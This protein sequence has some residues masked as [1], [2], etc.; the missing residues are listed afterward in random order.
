MSDFTDFI[1]KLWR[2]RLFGFW[3]FQPR[4]VSHPDPGFFNQLVHNNNR[5]AF[6]LL[7]ASPA[8]VA[9]FRE[10]VASFCLFL[11]VCHL[12]LLNTFTTEQVV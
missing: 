4:I 8:V 9:F 2:D 5:F 11:L 10:G 12:F 7:V 1:K 6:G 3:A